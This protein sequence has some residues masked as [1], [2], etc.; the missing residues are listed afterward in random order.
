MRKKCVSKCS[1]KKQLFF[2]N[3]REIQINSCDMMKG[4]MVP[5]IKTLAHV[6][7]FINQ[8]FLLM[9]V[10]TFLIVIHEQ[11]F[12]SVFYLTAFILF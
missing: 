11:I 1:V 8:K 7:N 6:V 4:S 12:G 9:C 5:R 2:F 10:P 3:E